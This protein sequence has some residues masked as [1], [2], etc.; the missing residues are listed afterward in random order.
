MVLGVPILKHFVGSAS[1]RQTEFLGK[2]FCI[3]VLVNLTSFLLTSRSQ[4]T[5]NT[6]KHVQ[7]KEFL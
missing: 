3:T 1:S 5:E 4:D 6:V 2:L 7:L